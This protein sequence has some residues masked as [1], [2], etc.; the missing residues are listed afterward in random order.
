MNNDNFSSL[1]P[2]HT[3][4]SQIPTWTWHLIYPILKYFMFLTTWAL[5]LHSRPATR[6]IAV[7][8][9]ASQSWRRLRAEPNSQWFVAS[10]QHNMSTSE[11]REVVW[12]F[13]SFLIY[14]L[15]SGAHVGLYSLTLVSNTSSYNKPS[16]RAI[17]SSLNFSTTS[18]PKSDADSKPKWRSRTR[19]TKLRQNIYPNTRKSKVGG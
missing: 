11:D 8:D 9:T 10:N 19:R 13:C 1:F 6:T 17:L 4:I 3:I 2:S 7:L 14:I 16:I 12:I 18:T 15:K 5:G